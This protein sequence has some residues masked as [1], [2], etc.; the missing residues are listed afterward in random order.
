MA[1][2]D[3]LQGQKRKTTAVT[4]VLCVA[5]IQVRKGLHYLVEAVGL[6]NRQSERFSL[7]LVGRCADKAYYDA[8]RRMNIPFNHVPHVSNEDMVHFM[9][10]FDIFVLPSIEDGFGVVV[11]EALEAGLPVVT[12]ANCGAADVIVP[13]KNGFIVPAQHAKALADAIF[14]ATQLAP[15]QNAPLSQE[16]YN[17]PEYA[18]RIADLYE[19]C[20]RSKA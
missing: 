6:L 13:G 12:T 7:T 9:D 18:L 19:D 20:V 10:G 15:T 16:I 4:R 3:A 5:G 17:W 1:R 14:D 8:L 11:T 2:K